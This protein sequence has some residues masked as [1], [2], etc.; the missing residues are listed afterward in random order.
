[1]DIR[2]PH[3]EQRSR[4]PRDA[5]FL[6]PCQEQCLI[7]GEAT[8]HFK[9]RKTV[10]ILEPSFVLVFLYVCIYVCA[11]HNLRYKLRIYLFRITW[12]LGV[13]PRFVFVFNNNH[14]YLELTMMMSCMLLLMN[15]WWSLLPYSFLCLDCIWLS[16]CPL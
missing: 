13:Q 15:I 4:L 3:G 1:V 2:T 7:M 5:N 8:L 9:H 16:L 10:T 12:L 6:L 11:F 14:R